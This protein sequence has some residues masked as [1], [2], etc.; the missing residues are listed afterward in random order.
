MKKT[1]LIFSTLLSVYFVGAQNI[2]DTVTDANGILYTITSLSPDPNEV[3]VADNRTNTPLP[4]NLVI[5]A[6]VTDVNGTYNVVSFVADAFRD[7]DIETV[8]IQAPIASFGNNRVF[9]GCTSLTSVVLP[10]TLTVIDREVFRYVNLQSINLENVVEFGVSAFR[11]GSLPASAD[12]SNIEIIGSNSLSRT[13]MGATEMNFPS[14]TTVGGFAFYQNHALQTV[15]IGE[16]ITTLE[17]GVF[18]DLHGLTTLILPKSITTF[19]N[20]GSDTASNPAIT[21]CPLLANITVLWDTS[22]TIP[23]LPPNM[24]AESDVTTITLNIPGGT[25]ALYTAE[26]TWQDMNIIDPTLSNDEFNLESDFTLYPNP[27]NLGY[28]NISSKS[29]AQV[30]VFVFDILG[31]EVIAETVTDKLDVSTLKAGVYI[32]KAVQEGAEITKR[33]VVK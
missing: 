25:S 13:S 14:A 7:S 26:T 5:P 30:D 18:S 8:E 11:E 17:S 28:V 12:L 1:L 9:Q 3:E 15:T 16:G 6:T 33:L 20:D 23:A 24:F 2:G 21:K 27:T 10:S 4:T 19:S 22:G 29:N 32:V 31:K